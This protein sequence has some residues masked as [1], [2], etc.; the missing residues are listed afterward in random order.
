MYRNLIVDVVELFF[1]HSAVGH[2]LAVA[3]LLAPGVGNLLAQAGHLLVEVELAAGGGSTGC[4]ELFF[5]AFELGAL[6]A[7]LRVIDLPHLCVGGDFLSL[8]HKKLLQLAGG[9]GRNGDF[10]GLKGAGGVVL[11][12]FLGTPREQ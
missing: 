12:F 6:Q 1:R 3:G 2:E 10:G 9:F 5:G 11:L 7:Q 8:G 4:G